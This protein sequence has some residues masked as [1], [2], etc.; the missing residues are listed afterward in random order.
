MRERKPSGVGESSPDH[1]TETDRKLFRLPSDM[2]CRWELHRSWVFNGRRYT[3][4]GALM[5]I[6]PAPGEPDTAGT[7]PR[8]VELI[9][10]NYNVHDAGGVWSTA[11]LPGPAAGEGV[12]LQKCSHCQGKGCLDCDYEGET[13]SGAIVRLTPENWFRVCLLWV[14][15]GLPNVRWKLIG[16]D[17]PLVFH[18]NGGVG[19]VMPIEV[20]DDP[21]NPEMFWNPNAKT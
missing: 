15:N 6:E 8:D 18:C 11:R 21:S 20:D 13:W 1:I 3:S 14:V 2:P 4:D 17:E 9:V 12:P 7:F 16:K 10:A 19:L 5:L